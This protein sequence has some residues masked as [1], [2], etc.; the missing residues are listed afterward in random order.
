MNRVSQSISHKDRQITGG[1]S[2]S[3][4]DQ[5]VL[6]KSAK[7][8]G[9]IAYQ[10]D[11]TIVIRLQVAAGSP[12]EYVGDRPGPH[13]DKRHWWIK[14]SL[15]NGTGASSK[16]PYN[17]GFATEDH[18]VSNVRRGGSSYVSGS[19]TWGRPGRGAGNGSGSGSSR[20]V[21][22]NDRVCKYWVNGTCS[23]GDQCKFL[24]SWCT[25]S[26]FAMLTQLEGHQKVVSGVINLGGEVGCMLNEG[27]W[28]FVGLP[29]LVKA[30][31][32]QTS[33]ELSLN[34]PVGQVYSLAVGNE[35]L[36]AGVQDSNILA[37]KY[38]TVTNC[39]EPVTALQGHS[40][41]VVTLVWNLENL[42]CLQTLTGHTSV[43]M[44]V[45][46]WD[47]FLLSCSLDKTIKVC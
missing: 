19:N 23:F 5:S 37:W 47:Q 17:N 12:S 29:N 9:G 42:Q 22:K 7:I 43:V 39:F 25:G 28:M 10:R 20:V 45:L 2:Y 34:G 6:S 38:N 1:V 15:N 4:G 26:C 8:G 24:H 13:S 35:L 46:C 16:R 3:E 14:I 36:F 31:N 33:A 44:S 18:R 32:V 11:D 30:W 21:V 27:P 41:A 40:A